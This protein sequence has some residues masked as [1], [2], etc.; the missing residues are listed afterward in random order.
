MEIIVH[1]SERR[2]L[3]QILTEHFLYTPSPML[4]IKTKHVKKQ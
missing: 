4:D 1:A 3:I 2:L